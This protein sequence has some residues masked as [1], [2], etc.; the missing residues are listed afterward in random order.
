[1][2]DAIE[3]IRLIKY[4]ILQTTI[5]PSLICDLFVFIYFIRHWRKEILTMPQNHV[6]LCLL[7]VS[8]IQKITDV[9]FYL[10]LLRWGIVI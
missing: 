1:M 6:I 5:G 9:L 7:I 8:F 3:R 10:Y 2:A 4:A